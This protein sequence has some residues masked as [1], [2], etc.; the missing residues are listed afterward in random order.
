MVLFEDWLDIF[1]LSGTRFDEA[2]KRCEAVSRTL[3]PEKK[4]HCFSLWHYP[5]PGSRPV[6]YT[7]KMAISKPGQRINAPKACKLR[8]I[9]LN[10]HVPDCN[11]GQY[12]C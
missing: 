5:T 3:Y 9:R 4:E 6:G 8:E 1:T 10:Q 7:G 11:I 12:P 2:K